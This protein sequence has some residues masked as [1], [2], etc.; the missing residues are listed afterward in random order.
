MK[1]AWRFLEMLNIEVSYDPA[2]SLP[3][4]DLE[5]LIIQNDTCSTIF[6]VAL[7]II[8]KT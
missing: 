6:R 2:I 3:G 7:F 1:T 8:A 5:K 4:L